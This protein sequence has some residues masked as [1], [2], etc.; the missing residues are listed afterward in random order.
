MNSPNV[1]CALLDVTDVINQTLK[2]FI[3][4]KTIY[5][6]KRNKPWFNHELKTNL[7]ANSIPQTLASNQQYELQTSL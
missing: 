6:S 2:T 4:M 7:W 1:D 5:P 3:P